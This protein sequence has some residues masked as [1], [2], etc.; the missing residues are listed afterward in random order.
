MRLHRATVTRAGS[1]GLHVKIPAF[2]SSE[3]GPLDHLAGRIANHVFTDTDTG[4]NAGGSATETLIH[5]QRINA[6]DRV[7]VAELGEDD[8]IVIG[9]IVTGVPV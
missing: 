6:G 9:R 5:S 4:D 1:S 7:L 8:Y 3:V 2:G